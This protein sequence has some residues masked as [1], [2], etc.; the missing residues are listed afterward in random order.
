MKVARAILD[1]VIT[2]ALVF[3]VSAI[4]SYIYSLIAHGTG[5]F[6][7]GTAVR[8]GIILGIAYPICMLA[9]E[10]RATRLP[11]A[12]TGVEGLKGAT[13]DLR[14]ILPANGAVA[15]N[16]MW[17]TTSFPHCLWDERYGK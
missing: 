15:A 2:F 8:L 14:L 13:E 6:D 7:W 17:L 5:R 12:K 3:V 4:V 11:G 9:R 10:R 16:E 1:G